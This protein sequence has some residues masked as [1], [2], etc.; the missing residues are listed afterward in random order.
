MS[1]NTPPLRFSTSSVMMTESTERRRLQLATT[2]PS[3][4]G[5]IG[6]GVAGGTRGGVRVGRGV[7]A[8]ARV[9]VGRPAGV[10]VGGIGVRAV[11][12]WVGVLGARVADAS[13]VPVW[14]GR[15]V[16]GTVGSPAR[17]R[18]GR[19]VIGVRVGRPAGVLVGRGV[20]VAEERVLVLR[21]VA[22]GSGSVGLPTAMRL[23]LTS[24]WCRSAR[25]T[26]R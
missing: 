16:G 12:A 11:C 7:G 9:R 10:A 1:C 17:V 2:V 23:Q 26:G 3:P 6:V 21:V 18:V 24:R 19:G 20:C 4:I 22:V 8:A 15:A 13:R 25:R 14:V 5:G